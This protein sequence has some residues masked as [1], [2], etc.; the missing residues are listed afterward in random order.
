MPSENFQNK[1]DYLK[2][3]PKKKC[4]RNGEREKLISKRI[5]LNK[6]DCL[7]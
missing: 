5:K 2:M 4:E 1:H 7:I 6:I 3:P